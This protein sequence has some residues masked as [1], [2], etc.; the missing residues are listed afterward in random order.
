MVG[1][2]RQTFFENE[3]RNEKQQV[4]VKHIV[5]QVQSIRVLHPCMGARKLYHFMQNSDDYPTYI[6]DIGRDKLEMILLNNGLR[7]RKT[8]AYLKTTIRGAYIF[9]NLIQGFVPTAI[10]QVWVSDLTYYIV[11]QQDKVKHY[12]ITLMM[13]LFSREVIAAIASQT[14]TAEDTS[15]LAIQAAF[16]YRN[17]QSKDQYPDL[18]VHSDGGGQFSDTNFIRTLTKHSI[19]SSM[20]KSAYEN[21]NAERINGTIKNEYLLPW[22]VNS[23][24]NLVLEL[25]RAVKLYNH[26]RPHFNLNYFTPVAFKNHHDLFSTS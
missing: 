11:V 17:I 8:K 24:P 19:R 14:M 22:G 12:Y 21:P 25:Q 4:L 26:Q 18:I 23:L 5:E 13:D 16:Q 6:Q 1:I 20:G 3:V 15:L 7:V 2:S 9:S 10:N